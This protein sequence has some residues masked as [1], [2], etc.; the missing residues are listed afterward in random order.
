MSTEEK[1]R[2]SAMT[3]VNGIGHSHWTMVS[4]YLSKWKGLI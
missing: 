3:M 4:V 2:N 1:Q